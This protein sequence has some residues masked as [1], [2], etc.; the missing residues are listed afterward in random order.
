[1]TIT[2]VGQAALAYA[3]AGMSVIPVGNDKKPLVAWKQYQSTP[4]DEERILAWWTE[5][6]DA[7]VGIVTG[8]ISGITVVDV[9]TYAGGDAS[10]FPKTYSVKTGNGGIQ[11][12]YQYCPGITVSAGAYPHLPHVDLRSDGG[13][14]VAA[15]SVIV[16]KVPGATGE[17]V[18]TVHDQY[19]PFP[20]SIFGE[21]KPKRPMR[22]LLTASQGT[23]NDSIASIIGRLLLDAPQSSWSTTI[24][25]VVERINR[26]FDPPLPER[27]LRATFESIMRT[28]EARRSEPSPV[29]ISADEQTTLVL[30]KNKNNITIKDMANVVMV[31]RQHPKFV[32]K[33]RFNAFKGDVEFNGHKIRDRDILSIMMAVQE[34]V[35]MLPNVAK[36]AVNDAIDY[37]AHE[38]TYDELVDYLNSVVWDGEQRLA[39]WLI[40]ACRLEDTQYHRAVGAQWVLGMIRRAVYPGTKFDYCLVLS[41]RQGV[42]KTSVIEALGGKWYKSYSGDV[43]NNDFMMML[44]GTLILD[45]DEGVAMYKSDVNKLKSMI[46][47][48]SDSYRAP[49]GHRVETHER[50]CVFS[51]TVNNDEPLI[52]ATGNRRFWMVFLGD[53]RLDSDWVRENR[54]QLLAEAYYAV[55]HNIAYEEVPHDVA[56]EYQERAMDSNSDPWS[57]NIDEYLRGFD[58]YCKGDDT[59]SVSTFDVY[60]DAIKGDVVH[61][62]KKAQMRIG[63]TLKSEFCME[64][65]KMRSVN[66]KTEWRYYLTPTEAE[67]LRQ[68]NAEPSF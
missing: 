2:K 3:V 44:Q 64:R 18:V 68:K 9:D 8:K 40:R 15:P 45:L 36:T 31:L 29:Q 14:V 25:P 22:T 10:M 26:T 32:G 46:T 38:N 50:R 34:N 49:Y 17:Y 55:R 63:K 65:R 54:D 24:Y 7:N 28:E 12:Y 58:M 66:D 33:I 39:T 6:P 51:M 60:K 67:R 59:F 61:F 52:D 43:A 27:E 42:G 21:Q 23:R 62:D 48:L 47:K 4:A 56:T 5:Y 16:P 37:I 30:R 20:L 41:G 53:D 57:A 35:E 13:F 1:M 19:A 11:L